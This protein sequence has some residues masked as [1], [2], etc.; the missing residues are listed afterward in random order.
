MLGVE[1]D[2]NKNRKSVVFSVGDEVNRQLE[3]K[4]SACGARRCGISYNIYRCLCNIL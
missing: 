2:E 1:Q 3:S 4:E